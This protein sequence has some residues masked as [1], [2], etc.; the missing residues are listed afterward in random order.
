MHIGIRWFIIGRRGQRFL[1]V[2][3]NTVQQRYPSL[4]HGDSSR[5]VLPDLGDRSKPR[6]SFCPG[7]GNEMQD[8]GSPFT[9]FSGI[10]ETLQ[11]CNINLVAHTLL[12]TPESPTNESTARLQLPF[13]GHAPFG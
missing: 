5:P 3:Q 11:G 8:H 7:G 4:E 1:V 2:E 9:R 10:D 6:R 13:L 12:E